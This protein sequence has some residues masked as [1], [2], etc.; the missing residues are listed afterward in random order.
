MITLYAMFWVGAILQDVIISVAH[1]KRQITELNWK[2]SHWQFR[3]NDSKRFVIILPLYFLKNIL[4]VDRIKSKRK[5]SSVFFV[6]C[7]YTLRNF[8][9]LKL[10]KEKYNLLER[11]ELLLIDLMAK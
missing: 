1:Q 7:K 4:Y 10:Y 9:I 2:K 5:S 8:Y 6:F 3:E 11:R